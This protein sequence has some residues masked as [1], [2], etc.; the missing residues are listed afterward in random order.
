M[1]T[2]SVRPPYAYFIIY[3]I[4]FGV[5]VDNGD[6]SQRIED[7]GK[8]IIKDV[9]NRPWPT[10]FRG[11]VRIHVSKREEPI[12]AVLEVTHRVGAP[13]GPVML[14]YSKRMP[15]GAIIG[16][17][18]IV[19]CVQDSK[20]PWAAAGQYQFVLANPVPYPKPIPWKGRL[21]LFETPAEVGA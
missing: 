17:V 6:G 2:L 16:E 7:S 19:D 9:E 15:R 21:G 18:D 13:Y 12:E 11:R 3:G 20:S 8:V 1:K 5:A 14:C 4:P 10:S